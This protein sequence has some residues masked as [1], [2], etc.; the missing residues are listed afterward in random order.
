[1]GPDQTIKH[2]ALKRSLKRMKGAVVGMLAPSGAGF[3][4][5]M[6][7]WW[8][9]D[10]EAFRFRTILSPKMAPLFRDEEYTL[11]AIEQRQQ[12]SKD[13]S[14]WLHGYWSS[15]D[16]IYPI[17]DSTL[18]ELCGAQFSL[19]SDFRKDLREALAEL[20]A[21][22]FVAPGWTVDRNGLVTASKVPTTK[23][24]HRA[25]RKLRKATKKW[26]V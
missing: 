1:M 11:L 26:D 9:W 12:L 23:A 10:G 3:E 16:Q 21:A 20:E 25:L 4:G 14:R 8:K 13:L 18:M 15:H 2:K 17:Y 24:L 7:D 5:N 19:V 22:G 6:I